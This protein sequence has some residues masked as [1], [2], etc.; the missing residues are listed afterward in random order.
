MYLYEDTKDGETI[1]FFKCLQN[2]GVF[3]IVAYEVQLWK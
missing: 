1:F 3:C 2:V